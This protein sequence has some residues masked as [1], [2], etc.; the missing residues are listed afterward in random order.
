[1]ET[2]GFKIIRPAA[3]RPDSTIPQNQDH[4]PPDPDGSPQI[5]TYGIPD[6]RDGHRNQFQQLHCN[7]FFHLLPIQTFLA[8]E[9]AGSRIH[10]PAGRAWQCI[11]HSCNSDGQGSYD[12]YFFT[13]LT[14]KFR[15][16]AGNISLFTTHKRYCTYRWFLPRTIR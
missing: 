3:Y 4:I 16:N 9:H 8:P 11:P 7:S 1:M 13:F 15:G 6:T 2:R 14:I 12:T 10:G 5:H